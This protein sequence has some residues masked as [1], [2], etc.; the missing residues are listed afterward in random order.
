VRPIVGHPKKSTGVAAKEPNDSKKAPA[1]HIFRAPTT[2]AIPTT[3]PHHPFE[4]SIPI[5]ATTV[6]SGP[7]WLHELKHDD[8]RLIIQR[9]GERVRLL[10]R[11]GYD[12]SDRYPLIITAARNLKTSSFV[13][14]GEAVWLTA[15]GLADFDRLMSRQ[16]DGEIKLLAFDLLA[17]DGS[18]IRCEP[19]IERKD[20]LAK[21]LATQNAVRL[22]SR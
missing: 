11:R 22:V 2:S 8:F 4:P 15:T 16:H 12:W 17:V 18:D 3:L 14:D 19:L 13:I 20:R 1:E 6:P 10:T 9:E 5:R 21:L 7:G